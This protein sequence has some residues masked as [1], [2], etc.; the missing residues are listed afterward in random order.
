VLD[1]AALRVFAGTAAG[2]LLLA[3]PYLASGSWITLVWCAETVGLAWACTRPRFDF[4]RLHV[5][6]MLAII[7]IRLVAYD[8]LL[9]TGWVG[10]AS[11]YVPFAEL[12]S[13]PPFAAALSF[14]LVAWLFG[15]VS[16][17]QRPRLAPAWVLA[18]GSLVLVAAVD[19]EAARVARH[20]FVP[21]GS[22]DLHDLIRAGLLVAVICGL[23]LAARGGLGSTGL[24]WTVGLALTATLLLFTSGA[25]LWSHGGHAERILGDGFGLG[26]LHGGVL[27][28]APLLVLLAWLVREAPD[29]AL[30]ISRDR[31]QAILLGVAL[32]VAMLLLRREAFAITH[33]PPLMDLF[34][35]GAQ[36]ASYRSILS[37]SY[38]LL[39]FGVY[40]TA[41]RKK[42]R[43]GLYAAYALYVFTALKVYLFDLESQ[44]QLY[45]ASSLIIFAAILFVSSYFANRHPSDSR[46]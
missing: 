45:R 25:L 33:A 4:L 38:A 43:A 11:R 40:V 46:A 26:W 5:L 37:V 8:D 14:G 32:A 29:G 28:M 30:G 24:A 27:L 20:A 44:N 2:F 15:R 36:R 12:R 31:I 18:I 42:L 23:W 10:D 7:G 9:S 35:E 39:A 22:S 6:A 1:A 13:W 19:G 17:R 3:T 34:R 21:L 41:I 16:D